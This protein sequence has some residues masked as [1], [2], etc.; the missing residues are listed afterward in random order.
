MDLFEARARRRATQWDL[1]KKT[2]IHQSRIS[3]I[4]RGY[5]NP[6]RMEKR[7]IAKALGCKVEEIFPSDQEA[8]H[9]E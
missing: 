5:I 6:S 9:A 8:N 7:K 3:L 4:E 1:R 2:G